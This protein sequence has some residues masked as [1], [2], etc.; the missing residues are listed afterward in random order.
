VSARSI[1]RARERRRGLAD[2]V[3]V[4]VVTI[5][6]TTMVGVGV[7]AG[8]IGSSAG[9]DDVLRRIHDDEPVTEAEVRRCQDALPSQLGIAA[10]GANFIPTGANDAVVTQPLAWVIHRAV[11]PPPTADAP[12]PPE[13]E[14]ARQGWPGMAHCVIQGHG[15]YPHATGICYAWSPGDLVSV[16]CASEGGSAGGGPCPG[17]PSPSMCMTAG[18]S[19]RFSQWVEYGI[20]AAEVADREAGCASANDTFVYPYSP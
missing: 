17:G 18:S 13:V 16:E 4:G 8:V 7:G 15:L 9:C 6:I 1:D 11:Q 19:G 10:A 12:L 2:L 3:L 5:V 20:D 14:F